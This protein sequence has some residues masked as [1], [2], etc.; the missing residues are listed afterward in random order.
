MEC[1]AP[2]RRCRAPARVGGAGYRVGGEPPRELDYPW[3]VAPPVANS[4]R[5][6]WRGLPADD[7][8]RFTLVTNTLGVQSVRA[9]MSPQLLGVMAAARVGMRGNDSGARRAFVLAQVFGRRYAAGAQAHLGRASGAVVTMGAAGVASGR[10]CSSLE[11]GPS[12]PPL[13]LA[14][15]PHGAY[16]AQTLEQ[17]QQPLTLQPR[18]AHL[19]LNVACN[20]RLAAVNAGRTRGCTAQDRRSLGS[21]RDVH[22]RVLSY[23]LTASSLFRCDHTAGCGHGGGGSG[24]AGG[25]GACA[26]VPRR[27]L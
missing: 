25:R 10:S 5:G 12:P 24:V 15:S 3:S 26:A 7:Q 22:Y 2:S 27:L 19:A 6:T 9:Y 20:R 1:A 13:Q 8:A 21:L 4:T 18:G 11:V 16:A 17:K 14:E 23:A